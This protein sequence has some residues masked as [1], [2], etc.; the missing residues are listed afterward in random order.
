MKSVGEAGSVE[1]IDRS[2]FA[3]RA[4]KQLS[5][6]GERCHSHA[7]EAHI[8][9]FD[10]QSGRLARICVGNAKEQA[11]SR[12]RDNGG[13]SREGQGTTKLRG[14]SRGG[15]PMVLEDLSQ[16]FEARAW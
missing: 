9:A 10:T 2:L 11:R 3:R 7:P 6:V 15:D 13:I 1:V 5:V 16:M 4:A 12:A 8:K 14:K